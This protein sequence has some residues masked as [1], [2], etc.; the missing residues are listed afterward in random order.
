MPTVIICIILAIIVLIGIRSMI[1]RGTQGCCGAG[2]KTEKIKVDK[3]ISHYPYKYTMD[4]E[5]MHCSHCVST[6]ENALN[7]L[8]DV[9]AHVSLK[10]KNAIVYAKKEFDPHDF[11]VAV[12]RADFKA[13]NVRLSDQ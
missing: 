3:D 11:V 2:G 6:V 1:K 8:G 9:Y 10:D 4:I 7:K 13:S 5:G 12:V